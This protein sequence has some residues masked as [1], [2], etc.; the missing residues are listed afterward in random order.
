M[1]KKRT[2]IIILIVVAAVVAAML[3]YLC[4]GNYAATQEAK[5]AMQTGNGV[6]VTQDTKTITF[7]PEAQTQDGFI[8]YPGGKVDADAYA[9]FA[10]DLA[11]QGVLCVIVK[12]P[13]DLAVFNVGGA[14]GVID[15]YPQ[16][17][18]WV[19]GGHSL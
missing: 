10:R 6:T 18:K 14:A 16:I 7:A 2:K 19:V 3:I 8:F 15:S 12:M 1:K 13:F 11:E 17:E 9:M 5:Q 4:T